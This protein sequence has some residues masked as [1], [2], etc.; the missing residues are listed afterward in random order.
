MVK[1]RLTRKFFSSVVS[2]WERQNNKGVLE[3]IDIDNFKIHRIAEIIALGNAT[4]DYRDEM[5]NAYLIIDDYLEDG[6][7]LI[8]L[9]L[10]L[11]DEFDRQFKIF[12]KAGVS[13]DDIRKEIE[14]ELNDT[15]KEVVEAI[16]NE[17]ELELDDG[18]VEE[19]EELQ[20]EE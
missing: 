5:D 18:D 20:D 10:D 8:E 3:I 17:R 6:G 14:K 13:V 9:Y 4:K 16:K 12:R 7:D 1:R 2:K 19:E 11:L 15:K